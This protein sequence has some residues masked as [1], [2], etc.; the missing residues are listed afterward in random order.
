MGLLRRD[1]RNCLGGGLAAPVTASY[2]TCAMIAPP[3][4]IEL[5][6]PD[7]AAHT[8][9]FDYAELSEV[10]VTFCGLWHSVDATDRAMPLTGE[11]YRSCV[12]LD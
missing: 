9:I 7:Y 6:V 8:F 1:K 3:A 12:I 10:S 5:G 11:R 2:F 4:L